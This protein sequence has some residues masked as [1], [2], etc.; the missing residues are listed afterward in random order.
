MQDYN[1]KILKYTNDSEW[2]TL[3]KDFDDLNLLQTIAFTKAA[4]K[5]SSYETAILSV[6]DKIETATIVRIKKIPV[7]GTIGYISLGPLWKKNSQA[8]FS[9]NTIENVKTFIMNLKS[10]YVDKRGVYLIIKPNIFTSE[11]IEFINILNTLGFQY[12]DSSRARKTLLIDLKVSIDEIKKNFRKTWRNN[13]N[14]SLKHDLEV[15]C[16]YDNFL[17]DE[18]IN[19]YKQM[20]ERKSFDESVDIY[21][22][23]K[24]NQSLPDKYKLYIC[25]CYK[26]KKPLAAIVLTFFGN[27]VTYYLGASNPEGLKLGA[28]Y[29][30]QWEAIN[31][32]KNIGAKWYDLGGIDPNSNPGGYEFKSGLSKN[33][34]QHIGRYDFYKKNLFTFL[35]KLILDK[36]N[37]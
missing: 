30:L 34:V 12:S 4:S 18:F 22:T 11:G 32:S 26:D 14:K 9:I 24:I 10:E 2:L 23:K 35:I 8:T 20:R 16:G 36:K 33:E 19:L 6:N 25:L 1:F 13:L 31:W 17:F 3:V 29:L 27:T 7:L 21:V 37:I 15:K 5:W 28:P